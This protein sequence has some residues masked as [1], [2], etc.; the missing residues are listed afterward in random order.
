MS[1]IG[2]KIINLR[3]KMNISQKELALK[4]G[5]STSVMNRIESGERPIRDE[6][7]IIIATF[8]RVTTDYLLGNK[9]DVQ[10][11]PTTPKRPR[12]LI[13]FIEQEEYT[14]N[15][16][17]ATQEDREKLAKIIEAL[18]WDAKEKNKRR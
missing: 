10:E 13:K 6:E 12:E 4:L 15:G 1:S 18:Y 5:F 3:E 9:I 8:F 2:N 14:L 11:E 7:I 17:I 16:Q